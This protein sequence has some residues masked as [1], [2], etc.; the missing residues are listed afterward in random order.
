ME[1]VGDGAAAA[2]A[3]DRERYD[4]VLMDVQMPVMDGFEATRLIRDREAVAGRPTRI[5][6]MTIGLG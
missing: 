6:A 1:V 5:A 3:V 4:V 2:A